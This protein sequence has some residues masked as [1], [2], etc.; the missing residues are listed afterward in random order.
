MKGYLHQ[1]GDRLYDGNEKPILLRGVGF[2]NWLLPEGYMW[3]FYDKCDRP[4]RIE[5]LVFELL[6]KE[7][8]KRFWDEYYDT[9]ITREDI[10]YIKSCGLNSVRLPVNARLL[11]DKSEGKRRLL[12]DGV[13]HIDR[14][15]KWCEEFDIYMIID[16]HAAPG[17]QTGTNIDDSTCDKPL[18]FEDDDFR[19]DLIWLWRELAARYCDNPYI[20]G[21]D[22]LNEPLPDWFSEHNDK[23]MPLYY[24]LVDAIRQV[25]NN[26]LIILEG[27]H[28][29]T[30]WSIFEA[31]THKPIDNC[32]LEFHKYWD[33]PD[34]ESITKFLDVRERLHYP[35]FM[36]EG[37]E[38]NLSLYAGVFHLLEQHKIGWNFWTYKKLDTHNSP[39]SINKPRDWESIIDYI[40]GGE[41]PINGEEILEEYLSNIKFERC[42]INH[43]VLNHVMRKAPLKIDAVCYDLITDKLNHERVVPFRVNDGTGIRYLVGDGGELSFK[44]YGGEDPEDNQKLCLLVS[45][46]EAFCYTFYANE[47]KIYIR[48]RSKSDGYIIS[49]VNGRVLESIKPNNSMQDYF[50]G[51]AEIGKN[52]LQLTSSADDIEIESIIIK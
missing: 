38:N 11:M 10:K 43:D 1:K 30:D 17:G 22:L 4:R 33:N 36:G 15:L 24:D 3:K 5:K 41:K 44:H 52:I 23:V 42:A 29:A 51:E 32:M 28:W 8:A 31:L 20:A 19:D 6:G 40:D 9:Y 27:V 46:G 13:K 2:G 35:I 34:I 12:E 25:D 7:K 16:M 39:I 47:E 14:L 37:G 18:L 21:Y 49:N 26:H 48:F 45:E 50:I